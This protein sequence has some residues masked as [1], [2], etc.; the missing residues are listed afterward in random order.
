MK[1]RN[2]S[3]VKIYTS[4]LKAFLEYAGKTQYDPGV[5]ISGFFE[6]IESAESS[7]SY[8][9]VKFYKNYDD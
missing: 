5:R 7:H 1:K 9:E 4:K 2:Y 8:M 3:A 6:S